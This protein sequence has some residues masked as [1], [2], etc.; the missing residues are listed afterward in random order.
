MSDPFVPF[1]TVRGR[2][3]KTLESW[4][5]S[6]AIEC[7]YLVRDLFG[8]VRVSVSDAVEADQPSQ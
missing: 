8:R 2:V 4:T 5:S 3:C 1:D 7:V 6:A